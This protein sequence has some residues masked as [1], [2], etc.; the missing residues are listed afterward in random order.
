MKKLL[1]R[2][3]T[4]TS[5][6]LAVLTSNAQNLLLNGSFEQLGFE[7]TNGYM[8]V[9]SGSN[10]ISNWTP[11]LNWVEYNNLGVGYPD[12]GVAQ[13]GSYSIDIAPL[14]YTGGGIKQ[15]FRTTPGTQYDVSFYLGTVTAN[16]RDGT[17]SCLV[18]VGSSVFSFSTTNKNLFVKWEPKSFVFT[19]S[20]ANSELSFITL[21]DPYKHFVLI[22]NV[23]VLPRAST[24]TI[25][26]TG[27]Y[28]GIVVTGHVGES[29]RVD[30]ADPVGTEDWK[31]MPLQFITLQA[32]SQY[33]FDTTAP[34][35]QNRLYRIVHVQ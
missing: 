23:I 15:S 26:L 18:T 17:G 4:L 7:G 2:I 24:N 8:Y 31:W 29:Y 12:L 35:Q 5:F 32:L 3:F 16:S 30:Y 33:V 19:A 22:D 6:G 9:P 27:F 13:D 20:D 34:N 21:D 1:I 11:I 10:T 28:P 25:S 14:T